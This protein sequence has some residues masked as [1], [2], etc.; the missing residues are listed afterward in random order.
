MGRQV[1]PPSIE[2]STPS[3]YFILPFS[4]ILTELYIGFNPV[5]LLLTDNLEQA[6]W[7]LDKNNFDQKVAVHKFLY[8][9]LLWEKF[10]RSSQ[11]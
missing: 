1:L 2:K 9:L 5:Y 11:T 6:F 3:Q 7:R 8:A 10:V 4:P